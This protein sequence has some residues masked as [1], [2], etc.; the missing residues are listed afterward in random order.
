ME[1]IAGQRDIQDFR[2]WV[3][4]QTFTEIYKCHFSSEKS[5]IKKSQCITSL[6][7]LKIGLLQKL[8]N[9]LYFRGTCTTLVRAMQNLWQGNQNHLQLSQP[10]VSLFEAGERTTTP[11]LPPPMR[12]SSP[13]NRRGPMYSLCRL[14]LHTL[15]PNPL[16]A[17]APQ[18]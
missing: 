3:I 9:K 7:Y 16:R 1:E 6:L 13:S 17:A 4:T 11:P 15:Y 12:S 5:R 14:P 8:A 18:Q 2:R 10:Q